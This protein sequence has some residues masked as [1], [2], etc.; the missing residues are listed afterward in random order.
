MEKSGSAPTAPRTPHRRFRDV[1]LN[2]TLRRRLRSGLLTAATAGVTLLN[3][4][5]STP[6]PV[7][8]EA[9]PLLAQLMQEDVAS[10]TGSSVA[11]SDEDRIQLVLNEIAHGRVQTPADQFNAALV[12]QHSPMTFRNA[13][14]V[15]V[16][17]HDYL[18]AHFL[19]TAAF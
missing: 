10:R 16:S 18:F 3:A 6:R 19:A 9:N 1:C 4:G 17:P 12:L 2:A 11:R 8:S 15:A 5:C 13:T 7:V 14:L